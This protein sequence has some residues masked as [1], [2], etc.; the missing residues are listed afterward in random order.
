MEPALTVNGVRRLR[1][2]E[3][4]LLEAQGIY[5]MIYRF[6]NKDIYTYKD[7]CVPIYICIY[8]CVCI[9]KYTHV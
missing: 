8:V 7:A 5:I 6:E 3:P 1:T 4:R 9:Y 2:Q